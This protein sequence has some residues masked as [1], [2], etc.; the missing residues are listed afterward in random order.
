[1]PIYLDHNA[2]SPLRV[3]AAAAISRLLADAGGNP[4]SVHRAGQ[5]S[6]RMLEA[7]RAQVAAIV[8]AEPRRIVFTSGG[9]ESNNLAIFGAITAAS[10]RRKI[11][12]SEIEHS[13]ILAPLAELERR[14][15]EVVRIAPDSDGRIDP[16]RVLAAL[17]GETALVALGLANSEVGTIQDLAPLASGCSKAGALL[18][19]DA[20]QAVGRIPVDVAALGCDLMT[21]SGHK[22]GAPAGVGALYVRDYARIAPIIFGGPHE[23]GVRAGTPN[24]L[25]AVAFGAA[26]EAA[27]NAMREESERIGS[28]TMSLLNRLRETIPG[29]RLNGPLAGRLPNTLNLTFPGVLGESMLIALDLEGVEVSMGS[30]CAAGAVEPSHVL[31]ALGRSVA[32]ARSSLRISLGWDNTADEIDAVEAIIPAVWRRVAAAE[33]LSEASAR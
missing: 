18:H 9:T 33:P 13:S 6:R 14:G 5:R 8:G 31:R 4:S 15:F 32:G 26:T 17:D 23:S 1:M 21:L 24:Q 28:L 30:A 3:E 22:L 20:A 2:G 19:I 12:S 10:R 25:S 27:I 11:I 16:A 29:L 7:A